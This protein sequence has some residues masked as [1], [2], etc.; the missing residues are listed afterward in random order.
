MGDVVHLP[1]LTFNNGTSTTVQRLHMKTVV[2]TSNGTDVV[3]PTFVETAT[4]SPTTSAALSN[5]L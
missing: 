1:F 2:N 5:T 4:T 3:V